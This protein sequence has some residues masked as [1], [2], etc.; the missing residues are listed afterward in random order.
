MFGIFNH[1]SKVIR[2][3]IV[4]L[5]VEFTIV[6]IHTMNNISNIIIT[7]FFLC[8]LGCLGIMIL[9]SVNNTK[10]KKC[11]IILI[12]V[13]ALYEVVLGALQNYRIIES[14]HVVF[15]ITGSFI[16]PNPYACFL[17]VSF[18]ILSSFRFKSNDKNRCLETIIDITLFLII[19]VLPSTKCRAAFCA[20]I[21]VI[22]IHLWR[23][24]EWRKYITCHAMIIIPLL[25]LST[26]MLYMWKKPSAD[27]RLFHNKMSMLAILKNWLLGSGLGNYG[28]AISLTQLEYFRERILMHE[29][30]L[31]IPKV[32]SNEC[33]RS[34]WS[35]SAFCDPLQIGVE[36]GVFTMIT[37]MT[38]V[39]LSILQLKKRG[40][41][42]FYGAI[43]LQITSLFSYSMELW[44]NELLL[45]LMIGEAAC[46]DSKKRANKWFY[47][48]LASVSVAGLLFCYPTIRKAKREKK[49][50]QLDRHYYNIEEYKLYSDY[51]RERVCSQD[52]N[53]EYLMEYGIALSRIGETSLSDSILS[54][55]FACS[56]NPAFLLLLGENSLL[57]L[58]YKQAETYFWDSFCCVP[59]R[60]MPLNRLAR[61]YQMQKKK[62]CLEN[63]K[64]SISTFKPRIESEI[65][66]LLREETDKMIV[67]L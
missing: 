15:S 45:V 31:M 18:A 52:C 13:W 19:I 51:C 5:V 48:S 16:N 9:F 10:G 27:W 44:Q 57:R 34:N 47:V 59:D 11:L 4:L 36:A 21:V 40:S 30:C 55:G 49:E 6:W 66:K 54:L 61:V 25:L 53:E 39:I 41:S 2:L 42:L 65:T 24:P 58:D 29:G 43:A 8:V 12:T 37:Y 1:S 22:A 38:L 17:V 56:G 46:G 67:E 64:R 20:F 26:V 32:Y 63:L 35:K 60:I 50:W 28:N 7:R 14:N 33:E 62:D 23:N 3:L